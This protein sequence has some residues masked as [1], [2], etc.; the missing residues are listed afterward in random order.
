M[1]TPITDAARDSMD[2]IRPDGTYRIDAFA[3]IA[4]RL[5]LDRSALMAFLAKLDVMANDDEFG[6]SDFRKLCRYDIP[7]ALAAARATFP[8][9]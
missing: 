5:E 4:R 2:S 1:N 7:K 3:E 6:S 9:P 8:E